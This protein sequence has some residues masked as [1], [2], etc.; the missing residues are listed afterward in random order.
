[1]I[2]ALTLARQ[3][4]LATA[5]TE[6]AHSYP[7]YDLVSILIFSTKSIASQAKPDLLKVALTEAKPNLLATALLVTIFIYH[8]IEQNIIMKTSL[9]QEA[10]AP[11]LGVALTASLPNL[12]KIALQVRVRWCCWL[13]LIKIFVMCVLNTS[14]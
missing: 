12:L 13:F 4:T 5:L 11:I 14:A 7:S 6:V 9:L 3:D 8:N 10:E 1:M 2:T